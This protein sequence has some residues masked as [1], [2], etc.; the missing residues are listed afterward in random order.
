MRRSPHPSVAA[1][2]RHLGRDYKRVHENVDALVTAGLLVRDDQGVHTEF[3]ELHAP[4]SL[5]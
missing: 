3:D 4:L 2:A 5:Q 1:L